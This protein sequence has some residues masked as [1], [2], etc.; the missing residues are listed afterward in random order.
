MSTFAKNSCIGLACLAWTG[1]LWPASPQ[2]QPDASAGTVASSAADAKRRPS[3]RPGLGATYRD[4]DDAGLATAEDPLRLRLARALQQL[5]NSTQERDLEP[6]LDANFVWP[7]APPVDEE[8]QMPRTGTLAA[9]PSVVRSLGPSALALQAESAAARTELP[10]TVDAL[11]STLASTMQSLLAPKPAKSLNAA[12]SMPAVASSAAIAT[13]CGE[14][15]ACRPALP[16]SEV[17]A[18]PRTPTRSALG[19]TRLLALSEQSLGAIRG[20]FTGINGLQVSFGIERTVYI[21]GNLVSTTSLNVSPQG[22]A[23]GVGE[24]VALIQ[25]GA[26]NNFAPQIILPSSLPATVIQNTL[27]D[28]KIQALTV[29]NATVSSMQMLRSLDFQNSMREAVAGSLRK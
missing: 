9:T 20:G 11:P 2:A 1:A 27:N 22:Q 10:M 18:R 19:T 25:S 14:R 28:Q 17:V 21:N 8:A 26:G 29:I 5:D 12:P 15:A 13:A 24:S 4:V 23:V 7:D 6:D 16:S 3:F